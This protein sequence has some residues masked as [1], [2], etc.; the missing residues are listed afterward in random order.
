MLGL[1]SIDTNQANL[2]IF[3]VPGMTN[4]NAH[5]YTTLAVCHDM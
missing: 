4:F 5:K 2:D 3:L 1:G